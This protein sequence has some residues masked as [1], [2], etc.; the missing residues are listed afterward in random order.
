MD[1][2]RAKLAENFDAELKTLKELVA[3][4]SVVDPEC[5]AKAPGGKEEIPFGKGVQEAIA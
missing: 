5:A 4:E 2:V 3:I 1:L